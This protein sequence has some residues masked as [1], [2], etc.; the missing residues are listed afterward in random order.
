[1]VICGYIVFMENNPT[2]V[3]QLSNTVFSDWER[4]G[5]IEDILETGQLKI[6]KSNEKVITLEI[7]AITKAGFI[8]DLNYQIFTIDNNGDRGYSKIKRALQ[9][10]LAKLEAI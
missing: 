2:Y 7:D 10:A 5:F 9:T 8:Y 3:I 4:R 1:M 6:I